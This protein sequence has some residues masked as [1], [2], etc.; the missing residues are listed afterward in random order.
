MIG[1]AL[2]WPTCGPQ[3]YSDQ[4][5]REGARVVSFALHFIEPRVAKDDAAFADAMVK[6]QKGQ[7]TTE[8][9]QSRFGFHVIQLDD[10]RE[11]KLPPMEEAR[12]QIA[13]ACAGAKRDPSTVEL[14]AVTKTHPAA[15]AGVA[16][17][18][19]CHWAG[20]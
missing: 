11:L 2:A 7:I 9:V 5:A 12:A 17:P 1:M 16:R 14:L 18:G 20:T 15:A 6:L 19:R 13:A 10:T 4:L 8:P 3:W